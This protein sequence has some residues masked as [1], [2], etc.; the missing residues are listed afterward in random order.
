MPKGEANT[1]SHVC[2]YQILLDHSDGHKDEDG[3][4]PNQ[5]QASTELIV[6]LIHFRLALGWAYAKLGVTSNS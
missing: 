2:Y 4:Q 6:Y 1:N 3:I 5:N